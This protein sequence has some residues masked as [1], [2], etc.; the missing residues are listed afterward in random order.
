MSKVRKYYKFNIVIPIITFLIGAILGPGFL[1]NIL[2][3]DLDRE[4]LELEKIQK[5]TEL[6]KQI[7]DIQNDILEISNQYMIT[8]D[9]YNHSKSSQLENYMLE[10]DLKLERLKDDFLKAEN[11]LALIENRAPRHIKLDIIPPSPPQNIKLQN[12]RV[13]PDK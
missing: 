10:L 9:E 3:I 8:R 13:N 7:G 2:K 11:K 12:L 4:R 5:T 1:W 6:R